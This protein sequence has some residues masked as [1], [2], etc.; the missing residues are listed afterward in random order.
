MKAGSAGSNPDDVK[1]EPVKR[2]VRDIGTAVFVLNTTVVGL[3]AVENGHKKPETL[4]ISWEPHN[5]KIAARK[6]RIFILES[7]LIRVSEVIKE[8]AHALSKLPR[9]EAAQKALKPNASSAEKV[10][11]VATSLLGKNDYL[12]PAV[13]LV[14][15]W[16][17]RIVHPA[18][19]AELMHSQK[20]VLTRNEEIIAERYRGLSVSKLL[21]DFDNRRPTLKDVSSL[22][23]MTI[24]F[25]RKTD[26]AMQGNLNKDE[27]DAW[28]HH[29]GLFPM[30]E[31]VTAETSPAKRR[32]SV[33]R[34]IDSQAPLLLDAYLCHYENSA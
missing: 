32:A 19:N 34:L 22:V 4:N 25:A 18:S 2:L 20:H 1:L 14:V 24:N 31:K 12:I 3:D 7:V 15:H 5:L 28:L 8:F 17:N 30:L 26:R 13:V 21:E 33:C 9:F 23:A 10:S 29:Y 27:L 6:S 11:A 16:R